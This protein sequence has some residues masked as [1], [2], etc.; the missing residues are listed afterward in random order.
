MLSFGSAAFVEG[1]EL[2]GTFSA[3]LHLLPDAKQ[4]PDT[5]KWWKQFPTAWESCR[6]D[7]QD[8]EV[9]MKAYVKWLKELPGDPVFLGYPAAF[10]FTFIYWYLITFTGECPFSFVALDIKSYAMA[11]LKKPFLSIK[12][13]TMPKRWFDEDEQTH[14]ALYD[15]IEQGK[16]FCNILAEN[17]K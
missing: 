9:A 16:L 7:L 10:D 2:I 14:I 8:P 13:R 15:A 3:N 11:I 12:K 5:M 1:K 6:K 4:D 17:N